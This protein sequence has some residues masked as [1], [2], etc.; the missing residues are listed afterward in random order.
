M[1]CP[2]P[3]IRPGRQPSGFARYY[4]KYTKPLWNA[5]PS[6]AT[7]AW[8]W[9]PST[10]RWG[11]R[12]KFQGWA[13]QTRCCRPDAWFGISGKLHNATATAA[14]HEDYGWEFDVSITCPLREGL[15][16]PFNWRSTTPTNTPAIRRRE[17]CDEAGASPV[18][19]QSALPFSAVSSSLSSS[20]SGTP[21]ERKLS[22]SIPTRL[23]VGQ[24]VQAR[25]GPRSPIA[26]FRRTELAP[27]A[28]SICCVCACHATSGGLKVP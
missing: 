17:G 28:C 20:E 15:S 21:S 23:G 4:A 8:I 12:D 3:T 18:S 24:A 5:H 13:G 14:F 10:R 7:P 19:K 22:P 26:F 2:R 27:R 9:S 11:T 6:P 25:F 1:R 16:F